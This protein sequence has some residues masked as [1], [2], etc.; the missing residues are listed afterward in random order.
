MSK[1]LDKRAK[2]VIMMLMEDLGEL[3][4]EAVMDLIRPHYMFDPRVARE[5]EIRRKAHRI[6][7]QFKDEKGTRTCYNFTDTTGL[8]KYINVDK[9]SDVD[10]LKS[11]DAQLRNKYLGLRQ[12]RKKV[13]ARLL[14]LAGQIAIFDEDEGVM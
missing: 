2:A 1:A 13:T 10:A 8:S 11:V 6:M 5:R 12:G 7:A 3:T 4:T 9:T 14:E